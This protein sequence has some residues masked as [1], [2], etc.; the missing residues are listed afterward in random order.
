MDVLRLTLRQLQIFVA[1]AQAGTTA[2][3]ATEVALS[4]SATSAAVN[5]LE[6]MLAQALFDRTGKRLVLNDKGRALLPRAR[7]LIEGAAEIERAAR[8]GGD[9]A[10]TLRIGA[11]TTIGNY[12]LPA[13]LARFFAHRS[14]QPGD[15]HS[16]IRIGNTAAICEA[17][18]AFE[19]D[20]GLIEGPAHEP[21]LSVAPW[22]RDELVIVA[23]PDSDPGRRSR[24]GEG[25]SLALLRE[26]TWLLREAGSGT[27]E[28]ADRMLLPALQRY[29][30]SI[31]LGSSE[32]IRNAVAAGLGLGC[33]STW[34]VSEALAAGRLCALD[35]PLPRG[36]RDCYVVVHRD[37]RPTPAL[38]AFKALLGPD[39][40][41][42]PAATVGYD[43]PGRAGKTRKT[44]RGETPR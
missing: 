15:W 1:V 10:E 25:V 26:Q 21:A 4:Q 11:S 13:L 38:T 29:R 5:E 7:A 43:P 8:D 14:H 18:A 32:A 6:R 34:V 9:G 12:V 24:A 37:K 3:A 41:S 35:T 22:L 28:V 17:V 19:L 23:A 20:I 44:A 36:T 33:M 42:P 27:R 31:E 16:S 40:R 39:G 2:A 30:R